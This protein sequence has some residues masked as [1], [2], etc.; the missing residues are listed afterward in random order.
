MTIELDDL[1][2]LDVVTSLIQDKKIRLAHNFFE[3]DFIDFFK[4][5]GYIRVDPLPLLSEKDSSVIYTGASISAVKD[6]LVSGEYPE[7]SSGVV[8]AQQC[9]RT[10]AYKYAFNND[11]I[12]FGQIYFTMVS[13][14]SRPGRFKDVVAEAVEFTQDHFGIE[15]E[16]LMIRTTLQ[17]NQIKDVAEMTDLRVEYNTKKDSF[18]HWDYGIEGVHGEGLTIAVYNNDKKNWQDIGNIVVIYDKNGKELGVEFG[19]GYEF[20]LYSA[21]QIDQALKLSKVY[22]KFEFVPGLS[23][24]YYSTLEA[25]SMMKLAGAKLGDRGADHVYKQYLKSLQFIGETL[26]KPVSEIINEIDIFTEFITDKQSVTNLLD[27]ER[28]FLTK[29][30]KRK[31]DFAVLVKNV[32]NYLWN[33]D[34]NRPV[35]DKFTDPISTVIKYMQQKGIQEY[36]VVDILDRLKRFNFIDK[37]KKHTLYRDH[38]G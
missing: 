33:V 31:Q 3:N 14:L 17:S 5:K 30:I 29:Y 8:I 12:P 2:S 13:N 35:K 24:K 20:F 23:Q 38:K 10:N 37:M 6:I 9:L 21:V 1:K 18:Y 36:E 26:K 4:M 16:R 7:D 34:H 11:W 32:G 27:E 25:V 28:K 22:E 15:K 19:Y